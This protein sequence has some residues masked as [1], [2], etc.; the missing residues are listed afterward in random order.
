[1]NPLGDL[2]SPLAG[3]PQNLAGITTRESDLFHPCNGSLQGSGG[4]AVHTLCLFT[5]LPGAIHLLAE[6]SGKPDIEHQLGNLSVI[7][8]K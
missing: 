7:N 1:V 2:L 5:E 3:D 6:G 8:P 4:V